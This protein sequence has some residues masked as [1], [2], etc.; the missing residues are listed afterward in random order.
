MTIIKEVYLHPKF[1]HGNSDTEILTDFPFMDRNEK[2]RLAH[3]V[4]KIVQGEPHE[5]M[6]KPSWLNDGRMIP[7]AQDY[8]KNNVWHYHCGPYEGSSG[9]YYATENTLDEN[10]SGKRSS[11]IYHYTKQKEIIIVLGYSRQHIPFPIGNSKSNPLRNRGYIWR[12]A[13]PRIK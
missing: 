9:T 6:N 7:S 12:Q 4:H 1:E 2:I 10:I 13:L 5:G 11:Q 8:M 3:W